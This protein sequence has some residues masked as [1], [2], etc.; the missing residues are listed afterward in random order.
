VPD[1]RIFLAAVMTDRNGKRIWT[2]EYACSICDERF[3]PDLTD[4]SKLSREFSAHKDEHTAAKEKSTET[5][6]S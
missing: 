5:A 6:S 4:P 1:K 2:G 3:R